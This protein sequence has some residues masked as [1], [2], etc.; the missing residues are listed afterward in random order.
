MLTFNKEVKM[1]IKHI[2][3]NEQYSAERLY[4]VCEGQPFG[5]ELKTW[6]RRLLNEK[7]GLKFTKGK[8]KNSAYKIKGQDYLTFCHK[9]TQ[10]VLDISDTIK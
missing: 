10:K 6:K 3:E 7:S 9:L 4:A 2:Q 8:A 5:W 1:A